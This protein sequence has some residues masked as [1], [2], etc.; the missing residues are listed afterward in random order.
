VLRSPPSSADFSG[1][2]LLPL[3]AA[4]AVVVGIA[5][6]WTY[7]GWV[8]PRDWLPDLV[9]GWIL[10]ACGLIGWWRRPE[11]RTGALLTLTGF[12]WFVPDFAATG[13]GAV[14]WLAEHALYLHRG[15]L[16][17]VVLLYPRGRGG[18]RTERAALVVAYAAAVV[19]PI[20]QNYIAT[21]VLAVLLVGVA[22]R[23]YVRAV[24]R[25]RRERRYAL[26]AS[27]FLGAV[28]VAIAAARLAVPTQD[29]LTTKTTTLLVYEAALCLLAIGLLVVLLRRPWQRAAV[30]DLVVELG[31][32]RSG[33][34]RDALARALGDPTLEVGYR[35]KDEG[36]YVDAAGH[37]L[38]LP[39]PGSDRRITRL[40]RDGQEVAALVHDRAVLDDPAL[41]EAVAAAARLAASNARLQ[42]EVRTQVAE[43][44]ASRRRLVAARDEERRRL[45]QR[46]DEGAARRL[47]S[48]QHVLAQAHQRAG[49]EPLA[50][51]ERAETQ[52]GRT[53][54]ELQELAAGLH[55]REL[56]ENGLAAA[57]VSLVERS[58]V[59]AELE[60]PDERL[61]AEIE[62][63]AFFICSEALANVAKYASASRAAVGVTRIDRLVRV[64]VVDD[65]V[66]GAD[67]VRGSGL[68]GL[69]DRVEALGG[70]LHVVSPPG[71]GTRISAEIPLG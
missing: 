15:P 37:S 6:E 40:E 59:P 7:Y 22:T 52:L 12:A 17:Q 53:T 32:T 30:T 29:A 19:L 1:R 45:E 54:A 51:I 48:L 61:P 42:A 8:N 50:R 34:L 58:P 64:E 56:A 11:S 31:E 44:Q 43:L 13:V 33:T 71:S 67:P 55:P 14:D 27:V 24:G 57:L 16:I 70:R 23:G 49:P 4:A 41:V 39:P 2:T 26:E 35:L 63:A 47:A 62:A 68:R 66:G 21:I 46:L 28:L 18:G 38:N 20:W 25:A 3:L 65:G 60:V 5:A 36:M 10:I 9:T 69:S